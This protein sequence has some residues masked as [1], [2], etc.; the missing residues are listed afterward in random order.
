MAVE[1]M[2]WYQ[3]TTLRHDRANGCEFGGD[4]SC[5]SHALYTLLRACLAH[6]CRYVQ[7]LRG[8]GQVGDVQGLRGMA[9]PVRGLHGFEACMGSAGAAWAAGAAGAAA[10][11]P[12]ARR[13]HG[14]V[15]HAAPRGT[16]RR[17]PKGNHGLCHDGLLAMLPMSPR[18]AWARE[19]GGRAHALAHF[20]F[21]GPVGDR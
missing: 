10:L 19:G 12:W 4:R 13:A 16:P 20:L 1:G 3:Q 17:N 2:C 8:S 11:H 15:A 18:P 7:G 9:Q 5:E 21:A 14:H 6:R